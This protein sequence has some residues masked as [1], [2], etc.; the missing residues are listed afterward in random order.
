MKWLI[1]CVT[2]ITYERRIAMPDSNELD[3]ILKEIKNMNSEN[4]DSSEQPQPKEEFNP[5]LRVEE[6]AAS[7][8]EEKELPDVDL[9]SVENN[10]AKEEE[11]MP[12]NKKEKR[13]IRPIIYFAVAVV[14]ILGIVVA[15]VYFTHKDKP[16]AQAP[17]TTAAPPVTEQI[18]DA[19]VSKVNPLTGDADFSEEAVG[20]RPI[21][22]VVENASAARPQWGI[23]DSK[24]P[25]DIIV[26]GEVEGGETRMLFMYADYTAVPSQIG[27]MRSARPPYIKFSEL[28]DAIFIH[29]G[30]SQTK[31][32][33][34]YIGA[35]TVFRVDNVDHI[36]QMT[37]SGVALFGRDGSRG[38]STEHTGVLYGSKIAAAIEGEGFRTEA[39]DAH[40]TKFN[41]ANEE[42]KVSDTQCSTLSLKFSSRTSSR[43]WTFSDED[44]MYHTSDYRTDVA[45]K[46]LLVLFDTTEYIAKANYKN[47]GSSE[48]YCNY[49]LAGGSGKLASNGTV[50]DINWTVDN[51]VLVIKDTAGN[52]V[53]LNV[54]T[55]WIGYAS[56]NNGGS[57]K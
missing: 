57:V 7:A 51:G 24:N 47:S 16:E 20:K 27:P 10:P 18:T 29:W 30:Q 46:N 45:R 22:C 23:N 54:G 34:A 4:G 3:D 48:I 14:I 25:P 53:S 40:Y 19:P 35:N 13:N 39:D 21:A 11:K 26:E 2:I 38:V 55:T 32:G 33:T 5:E 42:I 17:E 15:A 43:D 9:F 1:I 52:D 37:Y 6:A 31:K 36:N 49:N 12:E 41:F 8:P 28:F 44:K 50:V 56:S